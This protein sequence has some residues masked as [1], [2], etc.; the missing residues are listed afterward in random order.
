MP[1][2][3]NATWHCSAAASCRSS[4]VAPSSGRCWRLATSRNSAGSTASAGTARAWRALFRVF[5]GRRLLAALGRHPA[6]FDQASGTARRR[7][8]PRAGGRR[9]DSDADPRQPVPDLHPRAAATASR[10]RRPSTSTRR[11]RRSSP[12]APIA[13]RSRRA[14][15]STRCASCPTAP[16]MRSTSPTSSSWRT[17]PGTRSAWP[18][19]RASGGRVRGSA[20]GTTWWSGRDPSPS[21]TG[22]RPR[23]TWRPG[24]MPQDRAFIYSRLVVEEVR[25][26]S[27]RQARRGGS[28]CRLTD[29][30]RLLAGVVTVLVAY[31][32]LFGGAELLRRRG[33]RGRRPDPSST[34]CAGLLALGLPC[35]FSSAWPVVLM[36][37]VFAGAMLV[38]ECGRVARLDPRRPA[39]D[40]RR[41]AVPD[42]DRGRVRADGW[43]GSRL[44]GRR[45]HAR[46]R[47]PRR[48]PRR[49]PLG[50]GATSSIWG[51]RR[52]LEGSVSACLVSA[53]VTRGRPARFR[54]CRG[55]TAPGRC[56]WPSASRSPSPRPPRRTGF[57]NVAIPVT[58][59]DGARCRR[60]AVAG[61][62]LPW[63]ACD[64]HAAVACPAPRRSSCAGPRPAV[65][66]D[67]GKGSSVRVREL[68]PGELDATVDGC[69]STGR[70][71]RT[72]ELERR[73]FPGS[74]PSLPSGRGV[75]RVRGR[76][77]GSRVRL[78]VASLDPRQ[79]VGG[80]PVGAI[81]FIAASGDLRAPATARRSARPSR[82]PRSWLAA[83][84]ARGSA[85]R[86]SS[87][88]G[89]A[90][91]R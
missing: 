24:S 49:P 82:R 46:A 91:G 43:A 23:R 59:V 21:R 10:T 76:R 66:G 5:F 56:R 57:D 13:S 35:L 20:T 44:P 25:A 41:P 11:T 28:S 33:S 18:R 50:H 4:R 29:A 8:L 2:G 74:R 81:G 89:T 51:T 1:G 45:A 61:R 78:V 80:G 68:T 84:G 3:S 73:P 77:R 67:E 17:R 71:G 48:V 75:A 39:A 36:A 53:A 58:A 37:I 65:D 38:S 16:S 7:P 64:H 62:S 30:G 69:R 40:V 88:P 86:S 34:S 9:P 52:S 72:S 60:H 32:A 87:R 83:G 70:G 15:C 79:R 6:F 85:A 31:G 19:S 63:R 22:C 55:A 54:W 14:R 90:T 42:R 26:T 12:G 47:R 27:G